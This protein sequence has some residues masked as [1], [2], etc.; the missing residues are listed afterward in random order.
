MDVLRG[1]GI[2]TVVPYYHEAMDQPETTGWVAESGG[3]KIKIST[4]QDRSGGSLIFTLEGGPYFLYLD[5]PPPFEVCR[6]PLGGITRGKWGR[7]DLLIE[8]EEKDLEE[9]FEKAVRVVKEIFSE[10]SK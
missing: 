3:K 6:F 1:E 8:I 4:Q 9:T 10:T 7:Y 2:T 5:P